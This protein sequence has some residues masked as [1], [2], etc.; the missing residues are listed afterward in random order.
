MRKFEPGHRS[1][2][3]TE[4]PVP[5]YALPARSNTAGAVALT[6]RNTPPSSPTRRTTLPSSPSVSSPS[7]LSLRS[8]LNSPQRR[9]AC[10]VR[11]AVQSVRMLPAS[12][13]Q[14]AS[15]GAAGQQGAL[16]RPMSEAIAE[17]D[18]A[19]AS[20]VVEPRRRRGADDAQDSD[21]DAMP[22]SNDPKLEAK[23]AAQ[24]KAMAEAEREVAAAAAKAQVEA[25]ER[26]RAKIIRASS[27]AVNRQQQLNKL[28]ALEEVEDTSGRSSPGT[29][30]SPQA[31]PQW[32]PP[33]PPPPPRHGDRATTAAAVPRA[34]HADSSDRAARHAPQPPP[35]SAAVGRARAAR[36]VQREASGNLASREASCNLGAPASDPMA[37]AVQAA[38]AGYAAPSQAAL[39]VALSERSSKEQ[40]ASTEMFFLPNRARDTFGAQFLAQQGGDPSYASPA[41]I[42]WLQAEAASVSAAS[43]NGP[44]AAAAAASPATTSGRLRTSMSFANNKGREVLRAARSVSERGYVARDAAQTPTREAMA[45]QRKSGRFSSLVRSSSSSL[46]RSSSFS[47]RGSTKGTEAASGSPSAP[48]P[49]LAI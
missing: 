43:T 12:E 4:L 29:P 19:A 26:A 36:R 45:P 35:G 6:S 30:G 42:A 17:A 47:R 15:P 16:R 18:A 48:D 10:A 23:M 14:A 21:D 33:P 39:A 2:G 34:Q 31:P 44:L 22:D 41:S 40:K 1:R 5:R 25:D 24:A 11:E 9:D 7:L 3:T 8:Q 28:I 27:M 38:L 13:V 49:V 32:Q 20:T 46:L 37:A